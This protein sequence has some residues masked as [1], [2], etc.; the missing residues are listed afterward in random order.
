MCVCFNKIFFYLL[1]HYIHFQPALHCYVLLPLN[2]TLW[3]EGNCIEAL[4][5]IRHPHTKALI[6]FYSGPGYCPQCGFSVSVARSDS[7]HILGPWKKYDQ[8][9]IMTQNT[10][11][12]AVCW[13]V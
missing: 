3:N 12:F 9:P 10:S 8:N 6:M 11:N 2:P 5:M 1:F 7:V 4:W 13:T